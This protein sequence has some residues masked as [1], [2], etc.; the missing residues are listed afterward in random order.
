ME[1]KFLEEIDDFITEYGTPGFGK[2]ELLIPLVHLIGNA[3]GIG[4]HLARGSYR[5]CRRYGHQELSMSVKKLELPAYDPRTSFSQAL[6]YEMN[7]RGGCHLEGG[8]TAPQAYCAGYAEWPAD[9]IE[10]TPLIAK[11]ATLKNTALDVIGA[12][13][14]GSFS[15]NLDEYADLISAVTGLE[16]NSGTL[17]KLAGRVV[18][19]ERAFN[20]LCG[21]TRDDDWLPD[22]FYSETIQVKGS[23]TICRRQEFQKMHHEYYDSLGW[24][25]DGRPTEETLLELEL[26]EMVSG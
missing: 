19:L 2:S 6:C 20:L 10:G 22:R 8:Y 5:F 25:R 13:A 7:N 11:N 12:C 3:R 18:T 16:Y 23:A 14:Y 4:R 1:K 15:L 9:R 21:L 17:K 26:K 24:D